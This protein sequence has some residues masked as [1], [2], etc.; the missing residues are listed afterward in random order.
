MKIKKILIQRNK[1]NWKSADALKILLKNKDKNKL[2]S[3]EKNAR[4]GTKY[5]MS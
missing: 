5:I 2:K 1:R 3:I 4:N